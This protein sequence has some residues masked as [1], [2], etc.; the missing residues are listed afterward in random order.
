MDGDTRRERLRRH[1]DDLVS[2]FGS[3]L[4]AFF[5]DDLRANYETLRGTLDDHYPDSEIH[6]AVKANYNLGILSVLRDAGCKAEAYA[7][8]ELTATQQA[9]FDAE[10]VLLT[11]MNRAPE[12]IERALSWGVSHLLV[13]NAAELEKIIVAANA[14]GTKPDVL[15]RGNP[16]MEV[17]T[18]PGVATATRESKF[19]L[20]IESGRAMAVAET[21]VESDAVSLA[22]VQLHVGSQIRGVEPYGVAAREML[23]FAG[24]IRDEL[25]VE[26]DMLDLGG[27]FPVPY[28]ED[29]PATE[30]I[31]EHMAE[32]VRTTCAD[33]G[34]RE[35]TLFVEPGRRLVGNAG[36]YLA[37]VG[38]V[39]ETPYADFVVLDGGTNAVSSYW[40]YP[41]YALKDRKPTQKYHVAGPLCYTSD[42][43]SEDVALPELGPGDLLAVDRIGAYSLGSASH[44]N[45]EPKPPVVLVRSDGAHDCL[46]KRETCEDVLGRD[47]IPDGL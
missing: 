16:A 3:P 2:Q 13:D 22:G 10:D 39:K 33:L 47:R 28:D 15:I 21:A 4:Y 42:V 20:D 12:D 46:R 17:P 19:G 26:I 23:D 43:I 27:G 1:A 30:D 45:A 29:V 25:G 24:Q 32:T 7:R 6:F 31:V 36:T 35:P 37:T 18:H 11:G 34:L 8:C 5:E 40:P 9:G 44:T 38:V 41:V 14:T